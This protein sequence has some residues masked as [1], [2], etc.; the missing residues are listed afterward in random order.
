M[1]V[2][3]VYRLQKDQLENELRHHQIDNEGSLATLRQ[4][5]VGFLRADPDLFG[6]KPKDGP[7]YK[8][9]WTVQTT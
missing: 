2:S 5:M 1:A 7:D 3:W 8:K 4:R 9:T 6:D